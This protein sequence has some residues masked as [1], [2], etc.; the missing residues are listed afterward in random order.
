MRAPITMPTHSTPMVMERI[1]RRLRV[2]LLH[3]SRTTFVQRVSSKLDRSFVL[4][5]ITVPDLLD[6][7]QL[8]EPLLNGA[9]NGFFCHSGVMD[10][11][12]KSR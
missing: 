5:L 12:P 11:G 10:H 4:L 3:T 8:I 9:V 7:A 1:T 2:R 6:C